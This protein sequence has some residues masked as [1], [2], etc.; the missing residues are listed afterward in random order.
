MAALSALRMSDRKITDLCRI[1]FCVLIVL[2][3][4]HYNSLVSGDDLFYDLNIDPNESDISLSSGSE[5]TDI[6]DNLVERS[7]YW[8]DFVI[9]NDDVDG[10]T[11]KRTWKANGGVSSW[12]VDDDFVPATIPAKYS[13]SDA[14]NIVFVLVDDWVRKSKYVYFEIFEIKRLCIIFC[15]SEF[16]N[17]IILRNYVTGLE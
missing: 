1:L 6:Y 15:T 12:L 10:T 2:T 16:L 8:A 3:A 9:N 14:P 11:K 17:S 5:Y 4:N 13:Y 7:T